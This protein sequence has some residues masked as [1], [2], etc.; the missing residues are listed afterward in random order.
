M[1]SSPWLGIPRAAGID[2]YVPFDHAQRAESARRA[3]GWHPG[4]G[5]PI[6]LTEP[7]LPSTR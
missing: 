6:P 7:H 5:W 3:F 4:E 1:R 2:D